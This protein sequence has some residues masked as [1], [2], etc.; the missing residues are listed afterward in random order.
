[1]QIFGLALVATVVSAFSAA[2]IDIL[3]STRDRTVMLHTLSQFLTHYSFTVKLRA[4]VE[5]QVLRRLKTKRILSEED[6]SALALLSSQLRNEVS[7][8]LR[9]AFILSHSLFG[10]WAKV[11][12]DVVKELCAEAVDIVQYAVHDVVFSM[13]SPSS[14]AYCVADGTLQYSTEPLAESPDAWTTTMS[15]NGRRTGTEV[16]QNTWLCEAALWS[17]W[18]HVGSCVAVT[19]SR[20]LVVHSTKLIL[21]LQKQSD[22]CLVIHR[23]TVDYARAF[24]VRLV[25]S[26]PPYAPFPTDLKVAFTDGN[27]LLGQAIGLGMIRD[28]QTRGLSLSEEQMLALEAEVRNGKCSLRQTTDGD[29]E[30]VV[31]VEVFELK[32]SDGQV[33]AQIGETGKGTSAVKP[34]CVL[35]ATKRQIG[36]LPQDAMRSFLQD[37]LGELAS[38]VRFVSTHREDQLKPS[39]QYGVPTLYVRTVHQA[40]LAESEHA[41]GLSEVQ[42]CDSHPM[43]GRVVY[44][45]RVGAKTVFYAFLDEEE[46]AHLAGPDGKEDLAELIHALG[47]TPALV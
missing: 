7:F 37:E 16:T 40:L 9:K 36:K 45:T 33:F 5:Q 32:N 19:L 30:R 8:H 47:Q 12:T 10:V 44:A 23:I 42:V 34:G 14:S 24:H 17:E 31:A 4:R 21:L 43:S 15:L 28:A 27:E 38:A 1:M 11:D 29:L 26:E 46:F 25:T 20:L 2:M 13:G 41:L 39:P 18:A 3:T 22:S 35:P 6:V